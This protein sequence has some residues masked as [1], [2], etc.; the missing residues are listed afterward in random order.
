[1]PTIEEVIHNL[2]FDVVLKAVM[3]RLVQAIPFLGF[4][5]INP[6]VGFLLGKLVGIFYEELSRFVSFKLI[7]FK[8]EKQKNEYNESV[9]VLK[10]A[11][12]SQDEESIKRAKEEMRAKLR[13]LVSLSV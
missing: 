8:T 12:E 6:L 1:M 5:I 13:D 2:L 11:V 9:E 10:K 4:P 3:A 7:D